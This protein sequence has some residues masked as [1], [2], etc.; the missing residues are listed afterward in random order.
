MNFLKKNRDK[1]LALLVLITI[2]QLTA[3]CEDDPII[4]Q[5]EHFKAIGMVFYT[6][7]IETARIEKGITDDTLFVK[8]GKLSEHYN[9][10]FIS[11]DG[12][13][14]PPPTDGKKLAWEF[15]DTSVASVWQHEGEEGSFEFH[16]KGL[17]E[18]ETNIEFFI[19]HHDHHDYRSG[20]IP[21]KVIK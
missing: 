14:V 15:D 6:S 16:L 2:L 3:A 11:E 9:I 8:A 5:E 18:G 1:I 7:G 17:K 4:P 10:K 12:K 21:V 13:I 20:K 19:M